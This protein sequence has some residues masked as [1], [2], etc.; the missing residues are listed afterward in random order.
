[1]NDLIKIHTDSDRPTVMG[2]ELHEVL[3]INSNY[4]TWF[5]RMCE[6]GFSENSDF[7]TLSKIGKRADGTEMPISTID[8]QM[9]I[10]MAKE[11]CMIQRSK[12]G[13]ICRQ[14]FIDIE[15]RWN[16]PEAIMARALQL[17]N[18]QLDS[19]KQQNFQLETTVK[20][21]EQL[22]GELKPRADYTDQ[23]LKNTGLVTIT[24][25]AKDYGMSGRQM[26]ELLNE[27]GVQYKQ[28]KQ[29]LL[30]SKYHDKGYTHSETIP[31]TRKDGRKD[32]K[33]ETK[34]TQKGRLF[35]YD[36]LKAD[37][38]LP[39]IERSNSDES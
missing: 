23:I 3:E 5:K 30:Y 25:I 9:T 2:R 19:I 29:W 7:V 4:T 37:G 33:M 32:V 27:F 10:D 1:M 39:L 15:K 28:S 36:L 13:K 18:R 22:I 34:W 21:Q 35:I 38:I 17:A 12:I 6:Y 31:I 14:Y 8:H 24:Q 16:S 20:Q 11:I 26:N